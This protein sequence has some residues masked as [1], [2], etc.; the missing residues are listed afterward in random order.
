MAT[1]IFSDPL[2]LA[3]VRK[4]LEISDDIPTS[5]S[6]GDEAERRPILTS[7]YAETLRFGVQ[8]HIPRHAPHHQVLVGNAILPQGSLIL[9]NTWLAHSDDKTWNTQNGR[10]PLDVFWPRRFLVFPD[11]SSSGPCRRPVTP[12]KAPEPLG[13]GPKFSTKGLQGAWIPF[14]GKSIWS[15]QSYQTDALTPLQVDTMH[16][17]EDCSRNV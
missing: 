13:K 8:I 10:W 1:Q 9:M 15:L 11:E 2:L 17:P 5:A 4:E 6:D 7:L 16:V 14:G 3:E 12:D